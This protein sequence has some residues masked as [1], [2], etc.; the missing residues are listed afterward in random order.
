M[1]SPALL[2]HCQSFL[3]KLRSQDTVSP[4]ALAACTPSRQTAAVPSLM[5]GVMPVQW[6]Q[7]APARTDCQSTSPGF[8]SEIEEP[9]RS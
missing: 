8:T 3:R 6:N 5:A 1:T 2:P 9:A 7:S 4:M